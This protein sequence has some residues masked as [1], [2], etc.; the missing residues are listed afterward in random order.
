MDL[1]CP[2]CKAFQTTMN[3]IVQY[4]NQANPGLVAWVARPFPLASI[5]S[6]APE[7]AQA[8][9]CAADQGGDAEYFKYIDQIFS[10]TPSDNGLDLSQ[11]PAVAQQQGLNV[12][13]FTQCLS[14][15]KYAQKVQGSY[16]EAIAE[17]G[18]GTPYTL[19]MVGSDAVAL[20]GDQPYDSMRAAVDA[21]IS[22]LPAGTTGATATSTAS[23][24]GQ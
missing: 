8:A 6:K 9:E 12:N 7:E 17:G 22:Q 10:I 5:H 19:I 18:Q 14:S 4:Y 2:H 3:Q 1:E 24:T 13:T 15:S 21:V 16:N 20:S 23:T 11:L